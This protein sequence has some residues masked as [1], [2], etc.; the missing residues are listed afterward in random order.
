[1]NGWICL[2]PDMPTAGN[3]GVVVV[4]A[5]CAMMCYLSLYFAFTVGG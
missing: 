3:V 5:L 2:N 4:S 1:M